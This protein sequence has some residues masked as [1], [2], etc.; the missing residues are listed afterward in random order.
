MNWTEVAITT[1]G[2]AAEAIAEVLR[3]YAQD[4]SV[5]LEQLGDQN[6][7]E[8]DALEPAVTVKIYISQKNDSPALRQRIEEAI[9]HLG[10]LYPIEPPTFRIIKEQDWANAW[11]EHYTPFKV[12][13]RLWIQPSWQ[14]VEA[15]HPDDVVLTLDPGM[16]FGTGLH[17][18]TQMCLEA[19]ETFTK[20]GASILDVGMGSGILSI[21]ALRLGAGSAF[22]VDIDENAV[23][24]AA[25][26]A[27]MNG[28]EHLFDIRQG[29]L[30]KVPAGKYDLVLVNILA[31]VI[32]S[33]FEE[34][35]LSG[36]LAPDGYMVLS[37]IIEDQ[38]AAVEAA[39]AEAGLR[40]VKRYEVRD[41]VT[42]VVGNADSGE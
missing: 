28:V 14:Q 30:D 16:A 19:V 24:A 5:V 39:A 25:R 20:S 6:S 42:L 27:E 13:Q 26:N 40:I 38:S 23:E 9:Y 11:K 36:Y 10:R 22:G 21:A 34:A 1:D 8:A 7:P 2:E 12:G 15:P 37:G 35:G 32:I 31:P 33:L 4:Q 18:T 41:W 3:P 29:S 17:P